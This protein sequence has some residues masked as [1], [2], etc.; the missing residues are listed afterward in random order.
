ATTSVGLGRGLERLVLLVQTVNQSI[1][2]K[3]PGD[4]YVV[5][6]GEGTLTAAMCLAENRRDLRPELNIMTHCGGGN[7]KKQ[8]KRAEKVGAQYARVLGESEIA[9]G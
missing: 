5:A 1:E 4:M 9:T 3:N 6:A 8:F 2:I 7:F